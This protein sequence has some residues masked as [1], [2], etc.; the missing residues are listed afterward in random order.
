MARVAGI[1]A[2]EGVEGSGGGTK[3]NNVGR[4]SRRRAYNPTSECRAGTRVCCSETIEMA[5]S[6]K[7]WAWPGAPTFLLIPEGGSGSQG[8]Y[9]ESITTIL[10]SPDP[11]TVKLM[12]RWVRSRLVIPRRYFCKFF[13]GSAP[14]TVHFHAVLRLCRNL[15]TM[16]W[17]ARYFIIKK[18]KKMSHNWGR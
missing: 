6:D 10:E 8:E 7:S 15:S 2:K 16:K 3:E 5:V 4:E 13:V 11:D 1:E 17:I 18:K 14:S 9:S 12:I